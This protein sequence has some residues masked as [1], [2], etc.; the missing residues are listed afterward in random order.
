MGIHNNG[1]NNRK[2]RNLNF[3]V[4]FEKIEVAQAISIPSYEISKL[5]YLVTIK[6]KKLYNENDKTIHHD[7]SRKRYFNN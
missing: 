4:L 6:L 2:K 7:E 3:Y 5:F 1:N